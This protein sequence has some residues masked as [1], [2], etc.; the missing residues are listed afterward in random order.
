M[1]DNGERLSL[2]ERRTEDL[3]ERIVRVESL[4]ARGDSRFRTAN[5]EGTVPSETPTGRAIPEGT[6]PSGTPVSEGT[7][8]SGTPAGSDDGPRSGGPERPGGWAPAAGAI[9]R[10]AVQA[11]S[12]VAPPPA[13]APRPGL[14]DLL[15]GRVLAWAGGLAVLVG[16]VL[17]FAVAVSRG[18]VGEGLRTLLGAL[19]S[20][21]LVAVGAWLHEHRG[22]TD[23]ALAATAAGIAGLFAAAVVAARHYELVPVSAGLAA[24]LVTGA[25]AT[26]LAVRWQAQ[27]IAALGILGGLAA[28]MVIGTG[29]DGGTVAILLVASLSAAAVCVRFGWEWIA[30]AAFVLTAGQWL[31]WI[32][33][34]PPHLEA[35]LCLVAF[36]AVNVAMAVGFELRERADGVRPVAVI[37]LALNAFVLAGAGWLALGE[38]VAWLVGLG[39]AHVALGL[40]LLQSGRGSRPVA[41]LACALGAVILD[42]AIGQILSGLVLAAAW[43]ALAAAFA[44]L[45]A[46]VRPG[47]LTEGVVGAGLGGH[48][49][50]AL[51]H[52]L[53]VEARPETVSA[54]GTAPFEASAAVAA[55]ADACFASRFVLAER[56][57]WR[58]AVDAIGL[59]AVAYLAAINLDGPALAAAFA[60]EAI[61]LA[62]LTR[63][64]PDR[65]AAAGAGAFTALAL[66]HAI[67][68][69]APPLA[70]LD[71][72]ADPAAAAIALGAAALAAWRCAV[73]ATEGSD[74]PSTTELVVLAWTTTAITL[75]YSASI[76]LVTAAGAGPKAQALLSVLWGIAG[77]TALIAGLVRDV[78]AL[79]TG[80]LTLLLAALAKVFLY[81]LATLTPIARVASFIVLGLLLLLGAFAWQRIRPR[82]IPDLREVPPGLRG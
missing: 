45:L 12:K 36:G 78:P 3:L 38:T 15:A 52:A 26:W 69:E 23:A 81:D 82:P 28:P 42:I 2:V 56:R 61:L 40:A 65:V 41:L 13:A 80:A 14:E 9:A 48:L 64:T 62:E 75:L 68:F 24:A 31:A 1:V 6:V 46:R 43:A 35:L 30:G 11:P 57:E 53:T 76:L 4:L 58:A 25:V 29:T 27:G 66:G 55:I 37:L 39:A 73:A 16:I 54:A 33:T 5:A 74:A 50:L 77:V 22:R 63:H 71:G 7:V 44:P 10:T 51:G 17:L 18:W 32:A 8:P 34:E 79:R 47:G 70:L 19:T 49:A 59:A 20:F 60:A 72:V 67:G 21:T